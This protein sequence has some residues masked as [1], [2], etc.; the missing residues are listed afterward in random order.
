[1]KIKQ[2]II[3]ISISLL[4]ITTSL[5]ITVCEGLS[6]D[7][8]CIGEKETCNGKVIENTNCANSLKCCQSVSSVVA[9]AC[10]SQGY[11]CFDSLLQFC[12]GMSLTDI[13]C[14]KSNYKCCNGLIKYKETSQLIQAYDFCRS[15][16]YDQYSQ[17]I[18]KEIE[19]YNSLR[20]NLEGTDYTY[21]HVIYGSISPD[22]SAKA[23]FDQAEGFQKIAA[24]KRSYLFPQD[25][26]TS[27]NAE[28]SQYMDAVFFAEKGPSMVQTS[29]LATIKDKSKSYYVNYFIELRSSSTRLNILNERE[30]IYSSGGPD[31]ITR[32]NTKYLG[33]F[34]NLGNFNY[35][36][37]TMVVLEVYDSQN[38]N[39]LF[40]REYSFLSDM[41]KESE[42]VATKTDFIDV[43]ITNNGLEI[44][45]KPDSDEANKNYFYQFEIF[46]DGGSSIPY[47]SSRF[48][49]N[50]LKNTVISNQEL[51]KLNGR[52][53]RII[54]KAYETTTSTTSLYERE[55]Y[56]EKSI[57]SGDYCQSQ[58]DR[59]LCSEEK[60]RSISGCKPETRTLN[61]ISTMG[62]YA[63]VKCVVDISSY[64]GSGDFL[65]RIKKSPYW[66]Y[67]EEVSKIYDKEI[68]AMVVG[69]MSIENN[70]LDPLLKN[71]DSD[72]AGLMQFMASTAKD[73]HL[74]VTCAGKDELC[75]PN[76]DE[77]CDPQKSILAGAKFIKEIYDKASSCSEEKKYEIIYYRYNSGGKPDCYCTKSLEDCIPTSLLFRAPKL[78]AYTST[79]LSVRNCAYK[80]LGGTGHQDWACSTP[81]SSTQPSVISKNTCESQGFFCF[82]ATEEKCVGQENTGLSCLEDDLSCCQSQPKRKSIDD[83]NEECQ[84][85]CEKTRKEE[86]SWLLS[87]L[88]VILDICTQ[89]YCTAKN[90]IFKENSC[91]Y[92]STKQITKTE[93]SEV[94][95]KAKVSSNVLNNLPKSEEIDR[96]F[97]DSLKDYVEN[98][99]SKKEDFYGYIIDSKKNKE[100]TQIYGSSAENIFREGKIQKK[101]IFLGYGP[102]YLHE[103]VMP[104]LSCVEAD[105]E[106]SCP[107]YLINNIQDFMSG[108]N[109]K[110][111]DSIRQFELNC[112]SNPKC[113]C[114]LDKNRY[115]S[116]HMFGIAIDINPEDNPLCE[117]E[118]CID[119]Y[120]L[121]PCF[122]ASFE[123]YGF[124]WGGRSF[125]SDYLDYMHFDLAIDPIRFGKFYKDMTVI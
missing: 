98:V 107:G 3:I 103:L 74:K 26:T 42:G 88:D 12:E 87:G 116:K 95:Q 85:E 110:G 7:F 41:G 35:N 43:K 59:G 54:L 36:D 109:Q 45:I 51:T 49:Y 92:D 1:M 70:G 115:C 52:I 122:I 84:N 50:G 4:F 53:S 119:Q 91:V 111:R 73:N 10:E 56:L 83:F 89:E 55:K 64:S 71:K 8:K 65:N 125:G 114:L 86:S 101:D 31:K 66:P 113:S 25:S 82:D 118:D 20:T 11:R 117:S 104:Y 93:L 46:S 63:N 60:C 27:I 29:L 58:C 30:L 39:Y 2:I 108:E 18:C 69:I 13:A 78:E 34:K 94:D 22:I 102:I 5:A 100:L 62:G 44:S 77:R 80:E 61:F 112:A 16:N 28:G 75:N 76:C 37:I 79:I 40:K 24:V 67:I 6:E 38:G 9:S 121:P 17:E 123:R 99:R 90:C 72:A 14:S 48:T 23:L 96:Y 47:P 32:K 15:D 19:N 81:S 124:Q 97:C 33:D 57:A 68:A 105:I 120:D 21:L 106:V